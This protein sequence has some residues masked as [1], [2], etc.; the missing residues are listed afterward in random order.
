MLNSRN[1]PRSQFY[2][3]SCRY[4]LVAF[5]IIIGANTFNLFAQSRRSE[6]VKRWSDSTALADRKIHIVKTNMVANLFWDYNIT[7][8]RLARNA[9]RSF[10]V[11]LEYFNLKTTDY[12][13]S[14]PITQIGLRYYLSKKK[15]PPAGYY[16]QPFFTYGGYT[17]YDKTQHIGAHIAPIGIGIIGGKQWAIGKRFTVEVFFGCEYVNITAS[18]Y[19]IKG[20]IESF[21]LIPGASTGFRF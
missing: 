4:L 18:S 19:R 9:P 7:Y 20:V 11:K 16:V 3:A 12:E 15:L 8:E 13:L 2:T 14:G 17:I 1:Q 10:V 6:Y 5:L 21:Q